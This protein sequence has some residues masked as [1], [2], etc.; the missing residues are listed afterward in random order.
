MKTMLVH[1]LGL[2]EVQVHTAHDCTE[3]LMRSLH[4][5]QEKVKEFALLITNERAQ[6]QLFGD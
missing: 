3:F 6:R 1:G 4:K 5:S 2:Q